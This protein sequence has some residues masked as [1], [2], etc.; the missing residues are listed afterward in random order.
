MISDRL[1]MITPYEQTNT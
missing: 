1:N